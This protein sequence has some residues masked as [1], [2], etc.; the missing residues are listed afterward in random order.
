MCPMVIYTY[1]H[2][3]LEDA[4]LKL[5]RGD[6]GSLCAWADTR[7]E[8]ADSVTTVMKGVEKQGMCTHR[9]TQHAAMLNMRHSRST[10]YHVGSCALVEKKLTP[11]STTTYAC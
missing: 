6:L 2:S 5:L 4:T 7:K 10:H 9:P 1:H 11:T 8:S 3:S